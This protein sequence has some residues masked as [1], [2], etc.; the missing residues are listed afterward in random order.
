MAREQKA[1]GA[2][3]KDCP[4]RAITHNKWIAACPPRASISAS[5]TAIN[6][7]KRITW[8]GSK[9]SEIPIAPST[10]KKQAT[11]RVMVVLGATDRRTEVVS[12]PLPLEEG[13]D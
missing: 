7:F 10:R 5:G 12:S 6:A 1:G 3:P 4:Q 8:W 9:I 11:P 2:T 13:P